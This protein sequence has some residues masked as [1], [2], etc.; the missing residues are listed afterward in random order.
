ML[1]LAQCKSLLN[2]DK[3]KYNDEEIK[4]LR[5]FLYQIAEIEIQEEE[6]NNNKKNNRE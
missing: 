5:A 3:R 4:K 2:T 6:E 1:T